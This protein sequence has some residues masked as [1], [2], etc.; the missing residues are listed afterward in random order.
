MKKKFIPI[1]GAIS[2]GKSTFLQGF[3]GSN[4]FQAGS[5]VTTKFVCIIK[6]SKESKF[7]HV[8]PNKKEDIEFIPDGEEIADE[9]KIKKKIEEINLSK[10]EAKKEEI[11]Y[12]LEIPIKNISNDSLLEQCYFMDIPGLNEDKNEYID[13]IFSLLTLD[14]IKFEIFIF[15][16]TSIRSDNIVKIVKKLEEKKCLTKTNNLFILNKID[17]MDNTK[18]KSKDDIIANFKQSFYS[19]FEDD[20]KEVFF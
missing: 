13:I 9:E 8:I 2:S 14:D 3:L 5:T 12:M 7:Y 11:F 4:V 19:N 20:K 17:K 1:I 6:N 10:K 16:S 15:D 18:D